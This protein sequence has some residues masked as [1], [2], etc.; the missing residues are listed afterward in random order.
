MNPDPKAIVDPQRRTDALV[1]PELDLREVDRAPE[2]VLNRILWR[3]VK[4]TAVAYNEWAI[5]V[6]DNDDDDD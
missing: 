5:G 3:A 1:S 6:D 2:D 4:G